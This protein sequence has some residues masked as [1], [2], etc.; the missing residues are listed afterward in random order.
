M[1]RSYIRGAS[2]LLTAVLAT[3]APSSDAVGQAAADSARRR[4]VNPADVHFMSG[5]IAHHA[6]AIQMARM[7][8]TH[9]ASDALQRLAARVVNAQQDEIAIMQQWLRDRGQPVPQVDSMGSVAGDMT[10]HHHHQMPGMLTEAEMKQLDA[11]RGV[12][13]DRLFLTLMI[14]H[15]QGAVE[16]VKRLTGS[17]GAALDE[18][19]FKVASDIHVDQM[20]EISR[21]QKML[22]ELLIQKS[23]Q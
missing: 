14:K 16:M 4:T 23:S 7:A 1:T 10:G 22:F 11:A 20:T 12:E 19:V 8:P 15:H 17:Q 9:G 21:M 18:T 13:F 6:Q 5:M 2:A 3:A